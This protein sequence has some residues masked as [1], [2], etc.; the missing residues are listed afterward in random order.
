MEKYGY[1]FKAE[2]LKNGWKVSSIK[3]N[4]RVASGKTKKEAVN[5]AITIL[6][7]FGKE[8]TEQGF[9]RHRKRIVHN[10][11]YNHLQSSF[12][13]IFGFWP[14]S[15]RWL[16][17]LSGYIGLDLIWFDKQIKTPD[18]ISTKNFIIKQYGKQGKRLVE[19]M[20]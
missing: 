7:N 5:N 8:K 1:N 20:M 10:R 11:L 9:I 13:D 3:F 17:A 19:K 18:G 4:L 15:E 14:Q 16:A 6:E 12:E 2:K